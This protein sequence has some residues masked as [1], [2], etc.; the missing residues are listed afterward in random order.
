MKHYW[1]NI[2]ECIDRKI[3]MESQF[4]NND[5]SNV[6]I[7]AVTPSKLSNYRIEMS[8]EVSKSKPEEICCIISHLMAI[9]SGYDDGSEYFCVTEDDI[10]INKVNF[11]KI[12]NYIENHEKKNNDK[13]EILQLHTSSHPC[14]IKLFNDYFL[15]NNMIIKSDNTYPSACYYL[16]SREG[17][18][19]ILDK[20]VRVMDNIV[21][22]NFSHKEWCVSDNILYLTANTYILT[23]PVITTNIKYGSSI[24]P[25]H[26][27][28]HENCN[29]IIRE[30]WEKCNCMNLLS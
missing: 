7:S 24:H 29:I 23:Y 12:N 1:V 18:K 16:I 26:L 5:I 14:V 28:N 25:E 17:A 19:K 30:I 9:K 20:Y 13:I 15:D 4:K 6:R 2:D 3:H 8:E 10:I 11:D 22:I 27:I 21:Y